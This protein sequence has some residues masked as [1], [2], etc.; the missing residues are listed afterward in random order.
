MTQFLAGKVALITGASSE[1]GRAFAVELAR[2]GA[3]IF[4]VA[5]GE[6]RLRSLVA[7]IGASGADAAYHVADVRSVPAVYDLV[8]VVLSRYKRIDI[9]INAAGVGHR[10]PLEDWKR[11]EIG[12]TLETNLAG[13]IYLT[14]A[15]LAFLRKSAP[16]DIVNFAWGLGLEAAAQS[17]VYCAS[18]QG[19]VGFTRALARELQPQGVRVTALCAGPGDEGFPGPPSATAEKGPRLRTEDVT[20][21]LLAILK[22]DPHVLPGEVVVRPRA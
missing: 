9:L 19:L 4:G 15:A 6:E 2:E 3:K 7:E 18:Q 5:R 17:S 11:A 21:A 16:S 13:A 10:G 8:D 14:Q 1:Q 22:S 20:K 12:E